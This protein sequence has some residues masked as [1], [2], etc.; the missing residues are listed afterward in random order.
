EDPTFDPNRKSAD[1]DRSDEEVEEIEHEPSELV[2]GKDGLEDEL[3]D[4]IDC[5][6]ETLTTWMP[7]SNISVEREPIKTEEF[8]ASDYHQKSAK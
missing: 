8:K 3:E 7:E 4:L 5:Y 1:M 2:N 6:L